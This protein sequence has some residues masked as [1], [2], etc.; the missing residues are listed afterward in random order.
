MWTAPTLALIFAVFVAAGA[1]KGV[2][3][4]GLPVVAIG[5]LT[6]V[7]GITD[8]IALMLVPSFVT[9]LW[10]SATGGHLRALTA[11]LWSFLLAACVLI[12]LSS[13]L[14]AGADGRM[15]T[16]GLGAVL[17]VYALISIVTPQ[18]PPPG[19]HEAWLSPLAGALNGTI[20][21]LTGVF[22][23]PSGVYLQAL[24]LNR[25][26]LVQ[27]LGIVFT[28]ST[29]MIG[30][31][32]AGRSLIENDVV[33]LSA[34]A[35]APAVAGMMLGQRLRRRMPEARYRIAFFSALGVLGVYLAARAMWF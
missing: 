32:L 22:V 11:R 15:L 20:S 4:F 1:V 25:D 34:L 29:A 30:V 10:Q 18:V 24:G 9:N 21:G 6:T 16:G 2:F 17:V 3:G 7:I 31:A 13:G 33:A 14:L 12:W 19:R 35:L 28:V 27:G 23:V 8:A 5:I 26:Q